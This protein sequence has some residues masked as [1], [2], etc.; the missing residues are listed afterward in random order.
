M[1]DASNG[2]ARPIVWVWAIMGLL[3][4]PPPPLLPL[5]KRSEVAAVR[6][7]CILL[8]RRLCCEEPLLS[9]RFV[10]AIVGGCMWRWPAEEGR[11]RC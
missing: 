8:L 1:V 10:A 6:S 3:P 4:S 11:R 5:G 9:F 7:V 2:T